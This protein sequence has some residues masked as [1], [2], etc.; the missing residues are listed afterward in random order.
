MIDGNRWAKK[1]I[2]RRNNQNQPAAA[3]IFLFQHQA[4]ALLFQI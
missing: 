1:D 3:K 4:R 2:T